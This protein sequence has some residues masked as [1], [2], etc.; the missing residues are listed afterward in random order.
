MLKIKNFAK[1]VDTAYD[2]VIAYKK[3]HKLSESLLYSSRFNEQIEIADKTVNSKKHKKIAF[4]IAKQSTS[5]IKNNGLIP[6]TLSN[7]QK[8]VIVDSDQ[9]RLKDFHNHLNTTIKD[10][11][12][13]IKVISQTI[14]CVQNELLL[15]AN[16]VILVS[17][18]LRQFS[19]VYSMLTAIN[20]TKTINIAA[21]NP[22]DND[23]IDNIQNYVC[24][25]GATSLDQTNYTKTSL[26][27]NIAAA[28]DN[29]FFIAQ[30]V[31]TFYLPKN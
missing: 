2:K 7:N 30:I 29:I 19:E 26:S 8:I 14:E 13:N 15:S 21:I 17:A 12:L 31:N 11:G 4:D 16:L 25:Y 28:L 27:I 6:F 20:P 18:N 9:D 22:Y 3:Q 24:I 1:A 10:Q 5:I 23:Y